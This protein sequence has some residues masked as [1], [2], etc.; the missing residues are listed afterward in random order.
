M[1]STISDVRSE[2]EGSG[3][4]LQSIYRGRQARAGGVPVPAGA[5]VL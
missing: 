4:L 5:A 2:V 3:G 1:A